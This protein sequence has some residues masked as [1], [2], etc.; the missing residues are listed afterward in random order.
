M[1]RLHS[2]M[3]PLP[4]TTSGAGPRRF[5]P[6]SS[7]VRAMAAWRSVAPRSAP[8]K[9]QSRAP[10]P[11]QLPWTKELPVP[12]CLFLWERKLLHPE[13]FFLSR[14]VAAVILLVLFENPQANSCPLFL[15]LV[16]R[17]TAIP[18]G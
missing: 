1:L 7:I 5:L 15:A 17:P 9:F 16:P 8:C 11:D 14:L 18:A 3:R 4:R 6:W 13:Q 10:R 12:L 2:Q